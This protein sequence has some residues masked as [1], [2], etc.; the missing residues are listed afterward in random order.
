[1]KLKKYQTDTLTILRRYLEEARIAGPKTAYNTITSEEEQKQRLGAYGGIYRPFEALPDV[2]YVCLRLP[3]GGGKTILGAHS[4]SIARDAWVEKDYPMV[5]WLVP[6][7]T[8][9]LQT[10]EA[11]KN[12]AHPYRQVLDEAF[13]GRVRVFD[14]ADFVTIRPQDIRDNLCLVVGTI[15]TLRVNN[16]EGRKVYAH[17]ENL[18]PHYSAIPPSAPGLNLEKITDGPSTGDVKFSFANLLHIHRPLM[19][20]D[21]AHNAVTGLSREMQQRVNPCAIIEFTATPKK[22][23]NTLHNVS[24]QELKQA[25]MIKLPIVLAEHQTWQGAVSG[26][27]ASRASLENVAKSDKDYIRPIVLFQ[28]QDKGQEVTVEILKQHLIDNEQVPPERVA[29]ATGDQR[30]L[31]GINILDPDCPVEYVITKE[32]LKEGWDCPFAYVFCSVARIQSAGSV[33]QL[34]GRVL[35]MPYAQRRKEPELNRAYAHVSEPSFQQAA[36]ALVDKLIAMGFEEEDANEAIEPAQSS[37]DTNGGSLFGP[38][39]QNKP[40][41]KATIKGASLT[42]KDALKSKSGSGVTISENESGD[43][44]VIVEG[45]VKPEL[46][47]ALA[48]H[49][50]DD[51]RKGL[52]DEIEAYHHDHALELSPAERGERFTVP[53]LGTSIQGVLL[54]PDED[55]LLGELGGWTPIDY[56]AHLEEGEFGINRTPDTFEIDLNGNRLTIAGTGPGDQLDL[57]IGVEGWTEDNLAIWLDRQVR[58]TDVSQSELLKWL[59]DLVSYLTG[60]RSINISTLMRCKFV[61]AR[62]IREKFATFRQTAKNKVYQ[63]HLFGPEAKLE[64]SFDDGF[65]FFDDMYWDVRRY[66]G[67]NVFKKHF[68][69]SDNVPAFDGAEDGEEIKC[70]V[71]LDSL[72]E[73]EYWVRNVA[74]HVNSFRLPTVTDNFY[75][76]FVAKLKDGRLL[77]VEYK[78]ADRFND[79]DTNEKRIVGKLW[80]KQSG[81]LF[82]VVGKEVDGKDVGQQLLEKI[83]G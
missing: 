69:G 41:F 51:K 78:G 36:S 54:F 11:L 8:I 70:A 59:R 71:R 73:V 10:A 12:P 76:D 19:I 18:E 44:E 17:N 32:A 79:E 83:D 43:I 21:E 48:E 75:P 57:N 37:L 13:D 50:T 3:T 64:I 47:S 28:A 53:R 74:R 63:Q 26:A 30:E 66:H 68:L 15:Q 4:I 1:M 81:N 9:R 55:D 34:L 49:L 62:K 22:N 52:N 38:R 67:R 77:V 7:N 35:R 23:S 80:G 5:L 65:E 29:V 31:D 40:T 24:A 60:P 6:S 2:P 72:H 61:L 39:G 16:T 14:I 45:A 25:E 56:P 46:A 20:V 82:L 27:V 33:E 58:Q 42:E